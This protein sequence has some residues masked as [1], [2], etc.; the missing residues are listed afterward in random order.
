MKILRLE[1]ENIKKLK[2][3]EIT[4]DGNVVEIT[5]K[6]GAGKSSV[7]DAI[8]WAL[9]GAANIQAVPIRQG[10][11]EARIHLDLGEL[12]VTRKFKLR[13]D[14]EVTTSIIV[15]AD[16]GA[17]FPSPQKVLN[18]L[19]GVLSFDP[20]A[21]TR[22]PA[23]E[24]FHALR[25]F[26]PGVDFVAMEKANQDDYD[27]R[28]VL[29]RQAKERATLAAAIVVPEGTPAERIDE[30]PLFSALAQAS[31]TNVAIER[32]RAAREVRRGEIE[33]KRIRVGV[34]GQRI[35]ELEAEA[36]RLDAE[37]R[38]LLAAVDVEHAAYKGLPPLL[39]PVDVAQVRFQ[40]QEA[41]RL[42]AAVALRVQRASHER[43][44]QDA[45]AEA[46]ALT[47]RIEARKRRL[48]DE[49]AAAKLPVP[50]ISFGDGE[51][52]LNGL[53]FAQV[54]TAEQLRTS[55]AIAMANNPKLRVIRVRDGS[56]LDRES[57][58]VLAAAAAANDFQVWIETV[59]SDRPT[60]IHIE[61]GSVVPHA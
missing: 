55:I 3:V 20:L 23:V 9:D 12:V 42:N 25:K 21:F 2:C 38:A 27:H 11:S 53:P 40:L 46:Q 50:G 5:G 32:E 8:W 14:G 19:L 13:D 59:D 43:L 22:M 58:Q 41:Q 49:V 26:A 47:L 57:M 51:V 45:Q 61:D 16:N 36:D 6:N 15:A 30:A 60:A 24:Q 54:N 33:G 48:A 18:D 1:A 10:E 37:A 35:A 4:P 56:V 29:N 28:T 39:A 44:A 52:L 31:E 7:L 34:L 17:R